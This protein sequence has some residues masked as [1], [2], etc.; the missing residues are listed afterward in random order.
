MNRGM[1]GMAADALPGEATATVIDSAVRRTVILIS[2]I[3]AGA[4]QTLNATIANAVLPQMQGDLSAGLEEISW[5]LTATMVG[6]AIG[7]PAAGWLGM[8][9]GRRRSLLVALGIFTF[10]SG[11]LGAAASLEEVVFWR[12]VQG[13]AGGPMLPLS[14]PILLDVYPKR[15]HGMVM[16]FWAGGS[17]LGAVLGPPVGGIL[18]EIYNWRLAF[19]CMAPAGLLAL[20]MIALTVPRFPT[21]PNLRLD[22]LG[23]LSL[24]ACLASIQFMLDR[25]NRLDWFESREITTWGAVASV[26]LYLFVVRCSCARQPFL[27]LR[28][29]RHK[30]FAICAVCMAV[31]GVT[32]FA[33]LMLLPSLLGRLQ[34]LP[35]ETVS[36]MLTPR[37][38]GFMVAVFVLG[39]LVKVM[40]ERLMMALGFGLQGAAFWYMTTFDLTVGLHE[41]F[42]AGIGMGMGEAVIWIP[43]SVLAFSR[44]APGLVDYGSAVIHSSRFFGGGIGI[45]VGVT[46]LARSTQANRAELNEH[47]SPFHQSFDL[48]AS[49]GVWDLSNL[50]GLMRLDMEMFRQ[51]SMIA[52]VNDFWALT[53]VAVIVLPLIAFLDRP[54]AID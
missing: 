28:V 29:F 7:M 37:G 18:A 14:M 34:G 12:A 9:F 15:S 17:M 23:F 4:L 20:Y 24:A 39:H 5:V 26:A 22:W 51:A 8:R 21:R 16:G 6:T 30:N 1:N 42:I 45:S 25:G 41:I 49:R 11:A 47:L 53:I 54:R 36:L 32:S 44:L 40:D 38:I 31:A 50:Q 2:I 13:L 35:L 27:D 46:I 43:L 52:Y 48:A 33:A 19:V 3:I 10:A